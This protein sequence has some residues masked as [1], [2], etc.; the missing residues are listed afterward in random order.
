[1]VNGPFPFQTLIWADSGGVIVTSNFTAVE[2]VAIANVLPIPTNQLA[3]KVHPSLGR[4]PSCT[5]SAAP[6]HETEE[7]GTGSKE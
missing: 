4:G 6:L 5:A 2:L 7:S 1:M 3:L